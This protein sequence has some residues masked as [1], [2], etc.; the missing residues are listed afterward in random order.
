MDGRRGEVGR[1]RRVSAETSKGI[2]PT[3]RPTDRWPL[4]IVPVVAVFSRK[5]FSR[6]SVK[7]LFYLARVRGKGQFW[8]TNNG[9]R[10]PWATRRR[11]NGGDTVCVYSSDKDAAGTR[12]KKNKKE[13]YTP[14]RWNFQK[15]RYDDV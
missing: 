14:D 5:R 6:P 4:I 3:D 15:R 13:I 9:P 7:S 11:A 10:A 8:K 2:W 12:L 1:G